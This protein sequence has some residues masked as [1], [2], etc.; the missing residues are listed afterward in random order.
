VFFEF[1]QRK[2]DD[3]F[4]EGNFKALF[5]SLE[6]DQIRRGVLQAA[7][8]LGLPCRIGDYTDFY[9]GI[10]HAT[11]VGKQF[12]PD[13]PLLPNYKWVPIGYHGRASSVVPSG[14]PIRRPRGP[15][16]GAGRR[17]AQ[18]LAQPRLDLELELGVLHRRR[19][20][21]GRP[22]PSARPTTMSSGLALFNDWSARDCR[23]GNT[24]RWAP[25]WP[26]TSP[27][28]CRPGW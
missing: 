1:I 3:G 8:E 10:H 27:A 22:V 28:R 20:C 23:P 18:A 15:D 6:R 24:S 5:E 12:R 7:V 17:C 11:A 16:Q 14:T 13:N 4:G 21:A 2:G 25:S 9:T 26:R 19:Q